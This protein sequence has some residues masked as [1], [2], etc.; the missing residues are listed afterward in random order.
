M[1]GGRQARAGS[2]DSATSTARA[3]ANERP[4]RRPSRGG[5]GTMAPVDPKNGAR[6]GIL[7]A[8]GLRWP[9]SL[10]RDALQLPHWP[11]ATQQGAAL[12]AR[13]AYRR[14]DRRRHAQRERRARRRSASRPDRR[15][16]ARGV[17]DQRG[18]RA[19]RERPGLLPRRGTG[20]A[21]EGRQTSRGRDRPL[22]LGA[23][24]T[25]ASPARR[26][27]G[28]RAVLRTARPDPWTALFP[29]RDPPPDAR[30]RRPSRVRR[31]F[32]PHSSATPTPWRCLAKACPS[33][34]SNAN[35]VTPTSA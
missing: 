12:P 28:R 7:T 6:D 24:A 17:A 29:C 15:A 23:V 21:R 16:L 11:P 13:P 8:V 9:P 25:L 2:A 20:P 27:A 10:T 30:R 33:W 35:S 14:G 1:A 34:S 5:R 18:A 32:A 22:G 19:E 26:H 3:V 4:R 31:R